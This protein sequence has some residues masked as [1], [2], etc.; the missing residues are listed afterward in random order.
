M[1]IEVTKYFISCA[2]WHELEINLQIFSHIME[3]KL[4]N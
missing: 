3:E 4:K 2:K 1:D